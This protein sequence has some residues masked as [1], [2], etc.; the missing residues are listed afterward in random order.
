MRLLDVIV[1]EVAYATGS[2]TLAKWVL[3]HSA[4]PLARALAARTTSGGLPPPPVNTTIPQIT[5]TAVQ[6]GV[7]QDLST[8]A[9][10]NSPTGYGD[11]WQLSADGVSGWSD[12]IG[13]TGPTYFPVSGDATKYLRGGVLAGNAGGPAVA[14]YAY[15]NPVG[16]ILPAAGGGGSNP[17]T[18]AALVVLLLEDF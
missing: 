1:A 18:T 8:G 15:S 6:V 3:G 11:K 2:T 7:E 17:I 12:I 13:A 16:P 10:T 14:G 5:S 4:D 9:W